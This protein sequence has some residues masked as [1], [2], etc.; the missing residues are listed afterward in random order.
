MYLLPTNKRGGQGSPNNAIVLD[1]CATKQEAGSRNDDVT[2]RFQTLAKSSIPL[3]GASDLRV[4]NHIVTLRCLV[5]ILECMPR[6][7][8][9]LVQT[10]SVML[11]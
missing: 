4:I 3:K 11:F 1:L 9:L 5:K 7:R 10:Y 2:A 8:L 6:S